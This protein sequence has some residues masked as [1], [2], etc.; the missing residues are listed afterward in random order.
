MANIYVFNIRKKICA[1]LCADHRI[2]SLFETQFGLGTKK[3]LFTLNILMQR[4]FDVDQDLYVT[5]T[6]TNH[7][8]KYNPNTSSIKEK[9]RKE[10]GHMRHQ[11][12][13]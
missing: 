9:K 1:K 12:R 5:A 3:A 10:T 2:I 6:R 7:F 11:N 4:C 8:T 13:C